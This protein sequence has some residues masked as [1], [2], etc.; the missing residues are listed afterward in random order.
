S[1]KLPKLGFCF[2]T[3]KKID[4]MR[5]A[6]LF[7]AFL[8]SWSLQAQAPALSIEKIME[9]DGF[10]GFLP[11]NPFWSED[12]QFIYFSW[13][14]GMDTLRSLYKVP[15][16]GGEP[17]PVSPEEQRFLPERGDY[18]P[19]RN[20]KVFEKYG[21]IFLLDRVQFRTLRL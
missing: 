10:V 2:K 15:A 19:D 17:E 11:E 13:N 12:G 3:N 21:D 8:F 1:K 7:A 6:P 20:W 5:F 18:S 16:G 14:P 9:G 4:R